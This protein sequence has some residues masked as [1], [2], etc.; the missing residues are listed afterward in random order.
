MVRSNIEAFG[1]NPLDVTLAGES[2]GGVSVSILLTSPLLKSNDPLSWNEQA[3]LEK[4]GRITRAII[5]SGVMPN[6]ILQRSHSEAQVFSTIF[7]TRVSCNDLSCLRALPFTTIIQHQDQLGMGAVVD[8]TISTE[9]VLQSLTKNSTLHN[10]PLL[11]GTNQNETNLFLCR[12][13]GAESMN[14]FQLLALAGTLLKLKL[15]TDNLIQFVTNLD[16]VYGPVTKYKSPLDFFKTFT[17]DVMF[18]CPSLH[19]ARLSSRFISQR[20][21]FQYLFKYVHPELNPCYGAPHAG[22]LPYLFPSI[23][24]YIG[25]DHV[26]FNNASAVAT[27]SPTDSALSRMMIYYWSNFVKYGNP[28]GNGQEDRV[29]NLSATTQKEDNPAKQY[30]IWPNFACSEESLLVIDK[31]E[32]SF[33]SNRTFT[34]VCQFWNGLL[35]FPTVQNCPP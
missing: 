5:Q 9:H 25:T 2:A 27:M 26:L 35:G 18:H 15:P 28:N 10:I 22:E 11:I 33:V 3:H 6:N 4:Y 23:L 31:P 14:I 13:N 20:R 19:M 8:G 29:S 16:R 32:L 34:N 24:D 1:G 12:V 30:P 17:T 7:K 21:T